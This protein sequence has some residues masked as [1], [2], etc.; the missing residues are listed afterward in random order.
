MNV[1]AIVPAGGQGKRMGGSVPKQ[2]Q[3][4]MGHPILYYT[5]KTLHESELIDSIILVVP[6]QEIENSR[7]AWLGHPSIVKKVVMGGEKRQDSVFNGYQSVPTDTD[8][9]LV[10]DGVRPFLSVEMIKES[11]HTAHKFGAAVTG[12]PI[13]DTIKQVD[14]ARKVQRTIERE[15]LWRIQTP[16]AFR[17][18][19]L[20]EAFQNA[21]RNSFYGTDEGALIEHLGQEIRIV[22]GYEWNLKITRPED[23]IVGESLV[24]KLFPEA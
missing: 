6:E 4:L 16:Q 18:N 20:G 13:H 2:F 5:I 8:I 15:G 9:V 3:S 11:I 10:H 14:N 17:Y 7:K 12:I 1:C 21:Q 19:L 24:A 23:L 22:D